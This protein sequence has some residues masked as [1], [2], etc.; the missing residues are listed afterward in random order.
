MDANDG[1]A[2]KTPRRWSTDTLAMLLAIDVLAFAAAAW[3]AVSAPEAFDSA[4]ALAN[5]GRLMFADTQ[6]SHER[7]QV[8]PDA[9]MFEH[10]AL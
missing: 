3:L 5:A 9:Q 6:V 10:P 4:S 2:R 1:R 8:V 7:H